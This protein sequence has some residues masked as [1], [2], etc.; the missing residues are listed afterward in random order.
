[1][2]LPAQPAYTAWRH[3][4][5]GSFWGSVKAVYLYSYVVMPYIGMAHIITAHIGMAYMAMDVYLCRNLERV[6]TVLI[7]DVHRTLIPV[8]VNDIKSLSNVPSN[9]LSN[10]SPITA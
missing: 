10:S 4:K 5:F 9:I 1:M 2:A 8:C 3:H 7:D 6:R